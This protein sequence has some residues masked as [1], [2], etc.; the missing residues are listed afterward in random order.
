MP[1]H[2]EMDPEPLLS[3]DGILP[4][5][6]VHVWHAHI[7]AWE[8]VIKP[9]HDI[10][11]GEEQARASRFKFPAPRNQFVISRALLR[12]T[13][14]C[15][16]GIEGR[17]VRFSYTANS[18]PQ[19]DGNADLQFNLSH[20]EGVTVLAITSKRRVGV[21]VERIRENTEPLDLADRFFSRREVEWLRSQPASEHIP[22]FFN[23]WTAKESYIK[24]H[25]QGLSMSLGAFSVLPVA[26][27]NRLQLRVDDDSEES[28][29]WEM[30]RL[31]LGADIRAAI[32]VEGTGT[33][34][35]VGTW[36]SPGE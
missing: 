20:T 29:R 21:D 7:K 15:Y 33:R 27:S 34:I 23:C 1:V 22:S 3:L 16:L 17:D 35:R 19:L 18:K 13:L 14:G 12:Q 5:N 31:D 36:P 8:R 11:D 32:A 6:Q 28:D 10:L 30:W 9:L 25:G 4:D 24:A 2:S 26:G